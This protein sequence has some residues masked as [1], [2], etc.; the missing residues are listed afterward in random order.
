MC[1]FPPFMWRAHVLSRASPDRN[2]CAELLH[3]SCVPSSIKTIFFS[4]TRGVCILLSSSR[5][6][7]QLYRVGKH[8][9]CPL[10]QKGASRFKP[11]ASFSGVL[12]ESGIELAQ[13]TRRGKSVTSEFTKDR[14]QVH[15]G[16]GLHPLPDR[17]AESK[18]S[19]VYFGSV[20]DL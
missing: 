16:W 14:V 15:V 9:Q 6:S 10:R 18:A 12:R 8:T 2:N 5:T 4:L 3:S 7:W 13:P 20:G 19:K 1:D 17:R 11:G